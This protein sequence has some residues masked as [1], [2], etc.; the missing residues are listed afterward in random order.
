M[1]TGTTRIISKSTP[2]AEKDAAA[3][4]GIGLEDELPPDDD[5]TIIVRPGFL[6]QKRIGESE[7][8]YIGRYCLKSVLGE[9]GFGLVWRAE[10]YE[11]I[12]REVALK[13][14]KAGMDSQEIIARFD[15]ERQALAL[16]DHPNIARVLDA[17]ATDAGRPFFVMELVR[18]PAI[19]KYC[20]A[21]R[22]SIRQRLELF[23]SVC[24][25]VQHAHQK[26]ILHRD[27]KP[28]NILVTE[29]DGKAVPM[30]IDF[31][32][33]KALGAQ[34]ASDATHERVQTMQ[35]VII[36]TPQYM[37]PEQAGLGGLDV[38]TRSDIYSLGVILY[39]LLTGET[40]LSFEIV[41]HSPIDEVLRHIRE[42]DAK[43]PSSR[44]ILL[45]EKT[46]S[47]A[48]L[49][50]TQVPRLTQA[51][52]RDLDWIVLRAL[53]KDRD[54]RYDTA[55]SMMLD[56]MRYLN[57]EPVSATPPSVAYRFMK[58]VRRHRKSMAAA[59]AV[60]ISL[61]FG[62]VGT[63]YALQREKEALARE[64]IERQAAELARSQ[65]EKAQHDESAARVIAENRRLEAEEARKSAE[66]AATAER[67]AKEVAA[68]ARDKAEALIEDM[69][70]DLRGKLVP[71]GRTALL[72]SIA[73]SADKYFADLPA[74]SLLDA[75]WRQRAMISEFRGMIALTQ[76]DTKSAQTKFDEALV[77][78]TRR[79]NVQP[80]NTDRL[81]D[82]AV[83][84]QG[85]GVCYEE[86]GRFVEA[87]RNFNRQL[88]VLEKNRSILGKSG[89]VTRDL[90]TAHAALARMEIH[91][92]HWDAAKRSS[93]QALAL[94]ENEL[95]AAPSNAML[96]RDYA[97][98]LEQ[99]ARI[100][101]QS[102]EQEA[103]LKS[104]ELALE[105]RRRVVA[106]GSKELVYQRQ[107]GVTL[108]LIADAFLPQNRTADALIH[109]R[110]R[111]GIA[112]GLAKA[113]P[114]DVGLQ[115]DLLS[116]NEQLATILT[117]QK[118]WSAA[119]SHRLAAVQIC[120]NRAQSNPD[121]FEA[122]SA[123]VVAQHHLAHLLISSEDT[124]QI[125]AA[126]KTLDQAHVLLGQ[127]DQAGHGKFVK[128]DIRE[129]IERARAALASLK[130][131]G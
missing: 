119:L 27:L 46:R 36:G 77:I 105:L 45:T 84:S 74:A 124:S 34:S 59:A 106:A 78:L 15:A 40:P 100:Q 51:L 111:F 82:L 88:E 125:P 87:R 117:T 12:R 108:G 4:F 110:E 93:A 28:S 131:R 115:E 44:L 35:G 85:V 79:V 13:V 61:V 14:I 91:D 97:T 52:K 2:T 53:E 24:Q 121:D 112:T 68:T 9:G 1:D 33:A 101:S 104:L 38:D 65:A 29:I 26:A 62:L 6:P 75:Q 20:D 96:L 83:A 64:A 92:E 58:M 73:E 99:Q 81:R 109:Y 17:G 123:V 63:T 41:R 122:I 130:V 32:I 57:D 76:G 71:L 49:R 31:G 126:I 129:S 103:M 22:L 89:L 37:S 72:A 95:A 128:P 7:G 19:T 80:E 8:D 43:K 39:E 60:L 16:M 54:R 118:D 116:T 30:V 56:I 42:E 114:L 10:Q 67:Q 98:A 23:I 90:A 48:E 120:K 102:G 107:L 5:S 25:A 47:M 3:L 21:K 11:P 66:V 86:N 113:D 127:L 55:T 18:G 94:Y 50:H 70:I 69:L